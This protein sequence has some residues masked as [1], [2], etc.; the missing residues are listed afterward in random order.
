MNRTVFP[1]D[2][3]GSA[4][5][6]MSSSGSGANGNTGGDRRPSDGQGNEDGDGGTSAAI[7]LSPRLLVLLTCTLASVAWA[8]Y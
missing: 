3:L 4:V 1:S 6:N 2:T 7:G 8:A 5:E